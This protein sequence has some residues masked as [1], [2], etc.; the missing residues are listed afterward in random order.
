MR[1]VDRKTFLEMPAGVLFSKYE[2]CALDDIEIKGDTVSDIDFYTQD[3]AGAV[4][5]ND[6]NEFLEVLL[7]AADNGT[8]FAMDFECECRDGC[9]DED[10]LFAV[11]DH[12]DVAGLIARLHKVLESAR[13]TAT[14]QTGPTVLCDGR[15]VGALV[16]YSEHC[17]KKEVFAPERTPHREFEPGRRY[18]D[19]KFE[20][21]D[22]DSWQALLA[23]GD[24][25]RTTWEIPQGQA[26]SIRMRGKW[27]VI[28]VQREQGLGLSRCLVTIQSWPEEVT[29][30]VQP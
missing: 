24:W 18:K 14:K 19:I 8:S 15:P 2:P 5:C 20:P 13:P 10:Q 26:E 16:Q 7:D 25:Y 28:E 29:T 12:E 23:V 11:W 3:I 6:G 17:D 27:K 9:F 4:K 22:P 1:I 30:E 21:T